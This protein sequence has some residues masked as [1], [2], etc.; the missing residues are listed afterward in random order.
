MSGYA[1]DYKI[2]ELM[3]VALAREMKDREKM[4]LGA[5]T[6]IGVVATQLARITHAPNLVCIY[7]IWVDPDPY[8]NYFAV[9]TDASSFQKIKADAITN[10]A[11]LHDL[12][13]RGEIDFG[14]IRPAQMDQYGNINNSVIGEYTKP[15]VRLPGG[16]AISDAMHLVKRLLVY[17]PRH[18]PRVFVKKVDF[19]TGPGHLEEGKW[20]G[21]MNIGGKGPYKVATDLAILG[22]DETTGKMKLES[23]HPGVSIDDIQKNTG[24]PLMIPQKIPETEKPTIK[25]IKLIREKIDPMNMRDLDYRPR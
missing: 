1:K 11:E 20:R 14:I 4:Y 2:S 23:I 17:V 15:K 19:I 10:L 21:R 9:M 6:P 22:F 5:A 16:V 25:Q 3:A 24:F 8:T 12:W 7:G 13:Q 18:E